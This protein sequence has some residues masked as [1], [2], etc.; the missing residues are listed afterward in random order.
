MSTIED[1]ILDGPKVDYC[2][3]EFKDARV[4][5]YG[6]DDD[7][8]RCTR[9]NVSSLFVRPNDEEQSSISRS[10]IGLSRN[11]GPKG[12]IQDCKKKALEKYDEV[13]NVDELEA[14]F[15]ALLNDDTI[16]KEFVNKRLEQRKCE[17]RRT[18]GQLE[19]LQDGSQ[20]LDAIDKEDKDVFVIVHLYTRFSRPCS[21]LNQRLAELA[22]DMS[23]IK[24][25]TLDA[26]VAGL[27]SDFKEKGVPALLAYKGGNL[28]K[29]L[30]KLEDYVD[31]DFDTVQLK[32]LLVDNIL[33]GS[34]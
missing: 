31:G 33:L 26:G 21:T 27:S 32:D 28:V 19:H 22:K 1:K 9:N 11:T 2:E 12:V 13:S 29:S 34:T 17:T 7:E 16:L 10:H 4:E 3:S 15:Q 6:S 5:D 23:Y 14:E 8:N 25:V 20:L 18:F 24:F 30:V